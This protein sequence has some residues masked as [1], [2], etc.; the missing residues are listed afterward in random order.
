MELKTHTCKGCLLAHAPMCG[1]IF[2]LASS[3]EWACERN[4]STVQEI[5]PL[6]LFAE[7]GHVG[8]ELARLVSP[9]NS[10]KKQIHRPS[11]YYSICWLV[12]ATLLRTPSSQ[13][14]D[15]VLKPSRETRFNVFQ[16][17]NVSQLSWRSFSE[18]YF[19]PIILNTAE[20][21]SA[22]CMK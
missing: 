16:S 10:P 6:R 11:I 3:P 17:L 14:A 12:I 15:D 2:V 1:E 5:P 22:F 13:F 18:V 4:D 19:S 7:R 20:Y 9:A 21:S 8:R